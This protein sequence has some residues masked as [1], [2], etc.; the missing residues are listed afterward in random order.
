M[1]ALLSPNEVGLAVVGTKKRADG[2]VSV[3]GH[4]GAVGTVETTDRAANLHGLEHGFRKWGIAQILG[5]RKVLRLGDVTEF[6]A[7]FHEMLTKFF[8]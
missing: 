3:E 2:E 7:V 6:A 4:E 8:R 1:T 5:H